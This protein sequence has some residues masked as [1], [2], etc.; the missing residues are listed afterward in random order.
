MEF[1]MVL[2]AGF[3]AYQKQIRVLAIGEVPDEK[4][5]FEVVYFLL[6]SLIPMVLSVAL[7]CLSKATLRQARFEK[8]FDT[9]YFKSDQSAWSSKVYPLLQ[10]L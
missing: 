1:L 6:C 5:D 8:N 10:L 9:L 3:L 4:L 7:P 2:I